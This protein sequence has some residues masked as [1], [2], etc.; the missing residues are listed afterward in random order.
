VFTGQPSLDSALSTLECGGYRY[1][2]KTV[3]SSM[4]VAAVR[5]ASA[6]RREPPAASCTSAAAVAEPPSSGEPI[7]LDVEE[8]PST[9]AA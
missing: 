7:R 4:L 3:G 2:K 5:E 9:S 1:L 6:L 8:D